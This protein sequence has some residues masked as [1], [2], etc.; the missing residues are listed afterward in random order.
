MKII[1]YTILIMVALMSCQ[2]SKNKVL[3]NLESLLTEIE[4]DKEF[5]QA[6]LTSINVT[7][8]EMLS[9]RGSAGNSNSTSRQAISNMLIP[10]KNVAINYEEALKNYLN[11]IPQIE[12]VINRSNEEH[13]VTLSLENSYNQ[14]LGQKN[15]IKTQLDDLKVQHE[16]YRKQFEAIEK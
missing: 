3:L 6:T 12:V 4:G 5:Y 8:R 1:P 9:Q 10:H 15:K 16:E 11:M 2:D 14:F 7:H 13:I